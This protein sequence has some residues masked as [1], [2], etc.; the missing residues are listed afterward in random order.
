M[1]HYDVA[2]QGENLQ[3]KAQAKSRVIKEC[4]P[5]PGRAPTVQPPISIGAE[6]KAAEQVKPAPTV[7]TLVIPGPPN[8][9]TVC[10]AGGC[11]DNLG[12]RYHGTGTTLYGPAGKPCI[13]NV[14]WI[15]CR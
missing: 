14:D 5:V 4:Y 11:W 1:Q 10:D 8:K 6:R 15:D 13:R 3:A 12:N 9:I 2:A 7:Q